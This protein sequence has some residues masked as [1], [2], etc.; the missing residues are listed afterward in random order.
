MG[1]YKVIIEGKAHIFRNV[2]FMVASNGSMF[3]K[4][5]TGKTVFAS[6]A[7]NVTVLEIE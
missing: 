1:N 3:F 4:D 5:S 6:S 2:K 7:T